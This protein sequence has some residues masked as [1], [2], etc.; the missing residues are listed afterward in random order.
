M[1]CEEAN[2]LISDYSVGNLP[3]RI[4]RRVREHIDQCSSCAR[5]MERLKLIL[6][7]VEKDMKPIEPPAGLWNGV[8]NRITSAE[9]PSRRSVLRELFTRP[10]RVLS[11][12]V[13]IA[14]M[15]GA[16]LLSISVHGPRPENT[17]RAP[18]PAVM[19]YVQNHVS[20]AAHDAFADRVGLS[21]VAAMPAAEE[22]EQERL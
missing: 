21:F 5:E 13:G 8:Y 2:R 11:L 4:E 20:A 14:V 6:A 18:E 3:D 17:A 7:A 16:I 9:Q 12:G 19:E 1:K 22:Q 10:R 15:A